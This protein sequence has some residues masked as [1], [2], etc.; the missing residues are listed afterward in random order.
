MTALLF[1]LG[2]YPLA[3]WTGLGLTDGLTA[4]PPEYLIRSS[5]EWA[6]VGLCLVLAASP[7]QKLLHLDFLL[8]HRRMVA[9][10]S[11][12]YAGLHVLGWAFWEQGLLPAAMWSDIVNRLFITVG[13]VAVVLMVPLAFTS[14]RGWMRRLGRNWKRLHRL[15]YVVAGLELWHFWLVRAGKNNFDRVW[16][17]I[18]VVALLLIFRL[19][20]QRRRAVPVRQA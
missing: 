3:L 14:T 16:V 12:F 18:A 9:L 17:Y 13:T 8:R 19:V 20:W 1:I 15:V 4:N 2:L 5:G 7:L 11:F 6:L 10:Y